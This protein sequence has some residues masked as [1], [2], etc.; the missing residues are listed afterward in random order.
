MSVFFFLASFTVFLYRKAASASFVTAALVLLLFG[1][2]VLSKEHA[3]VL[4]A[5]LLLTDYYWNPGFSM[6]GIRRNWRVYAPMMVAGAAGLA[7]VWRILSA[8]N[9]AGFGMKEFTWDQYFFTECRVIWQYVLLFVIPVGQNLDPDVALSHNV[10]EHGALI[11]LIALAAV[12]VAAW[13]FRKRYPLESYGVFTFLLLIAPTSSFVPIH[14]TMAERRMYLPFIGLLLITVGVLRHWKERRNVVAATLAVVLL[15]EGG[16]A[17]QRNKLWNDAIAIW[18]DSVAKSPQKMRPRFQLAYAEYSAGRCDAAVNDFAKT[19][20]LTKPDYGLLVDWALSYDCAGNPSAAIDKLSEAAALE[21]SAHAYSQ[22][23][24]EFA[25]QGK[26]PQALDALDKAT[27]LDPN[28]DM[29]YAYRGNIYFLEGNKP[30]AAEEFR[31][32]LAINP[33]NQ[34]AREGLVKASQ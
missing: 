29:T 23:G 33:Q 7:F 30:R 25:K 10:F 20:Q 2:A 16:V 3:A 26:Y 1:A 9:S 6:Q 19:A 18:A 8:S 32:A 28:W 12:I 14:D 22:I 4:P 24:M 31:R 15:I 27:R 11:A 21:P 17:F 13:I 34:T 5:L